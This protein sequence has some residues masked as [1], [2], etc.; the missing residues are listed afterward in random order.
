MTVKDGFKFGVGYTLG[1]GL[2][3]A[4]A[5]M[6]GEALDRVGSDKP[7]EETQNTEDTETTE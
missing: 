1:M 7:K 4:L 5:K 3:A 6:L 2:T